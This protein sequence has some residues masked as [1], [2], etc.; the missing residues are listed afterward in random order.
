MGTKGVEFGCG[1]EVCV[2]GCSVGQVKVYI[3]RK[4]QMVQEWVQGLV[5][6]V[7]W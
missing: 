5:D 4:G 1:L 7:F 6:G 2:V 3:Q